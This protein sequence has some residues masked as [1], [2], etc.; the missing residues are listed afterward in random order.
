MVITSRFNIGV[1]QEEDG[2][3]DGDD[4]PSWENQTVVV[5]SA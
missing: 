2:E 3:D 4:V 5:E 1:S